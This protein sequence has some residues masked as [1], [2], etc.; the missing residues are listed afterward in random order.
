M[1]SLDQDSLV[2]VLV[3]LGV[4]VEG[5]VQRLVNLASLSVLAEKSSER[6]LSSDPEALNWET[7]VAGTFSLTWSGMSSS[8]LGDLVKSGSGTR[9]NLDGLLQ[10]ETILDEL[11]DATT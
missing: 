8:S 11:L 4:E 9:V 5:V 7:G 6:S 3:T 10:D 1:N 2:L